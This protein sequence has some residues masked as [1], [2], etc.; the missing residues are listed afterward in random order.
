M[1]TNSNWK[2]HWFASTGS[3]HRNG[4]SRMKMS[5]RPTNK[6]ALLLAK[7]AAQK[8]ANEVGQPLQVFELRHVL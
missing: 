8:F 4:I 2:I 1:K 6:E 3:F 5:R 7:L